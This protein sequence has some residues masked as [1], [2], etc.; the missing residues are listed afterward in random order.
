MKKFMIATA[1]VAATSTGAAFAQENDGQLRELV[2]TELETMELGVDVDALPN[3]AVSQLHLILTSDMSESQQ[4][5]RVRGVLEDYGMNFSNGMMYED[6]GSTIA[7]TVPSNQLRA[8]VANELAFYEAG[9]E[10]DVAT[11]SNEQVSELYL[12]LTSTM[13]SSEKENRVRGVLAE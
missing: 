3:S 2:S 9:A 7:V 6:D 12:I 5:N 13:D 1:L 4:N 8:R 11:M 10:A